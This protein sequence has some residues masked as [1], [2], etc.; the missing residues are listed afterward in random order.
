MKFGLR[1]PHGG[2]LASPDVLRELCRLSETVGFAHLAVGDHVIVPVD[3]ASRH[4]Y[5]GDRF[6]RQSADYLEQLAVMTFAAAVTERI[7]IVSAVMVIAYRPVALLAKQVATI[8][9]LS[10]GRLTIGCGVGWMS[11]EFAALGLDTFHK[12]GEVTDRNLRILQTL[13]NA[14]GREVSDGSLPFTPDRMQ[15][16]PVQQPH[17]P[18]WIGGESERAI[19][20]AAEFGDCWFPSA[21]NPRL[22]LGTRTESTR[23]VERF[24]DFVQDA[25]RDVTGVEIAVELGSYRPGPAAASADPTVLPRDRIIR[26]VEILTESG[27]DHVVVGIAARNADEMLQEIPRFADEVIR[28]F[29]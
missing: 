29:S 21:R 20:R 17:P 22:P 28:H 25:G 26:D 16:K 1:L 19:R 15:P 9:V 8:D 12:R 3:V 5:K 10:N 13:W 7:R 11:E 2:A 24:H 18:L 4:P 27:V 14:D 6:A 23:A